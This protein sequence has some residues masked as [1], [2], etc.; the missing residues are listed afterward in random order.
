M[1]FQTITICSEGSLTALV[2]HN[3]IMR[4]ASGPRDLSDMREFPG[5][6]RDGAQE[7]GDN[8]YQRDQSP[9]GDVGRTVR[10]QRYPTYSASA[11]DDGPDQ[12]R[13]KHATDNF[14]NR[15]KDVTHVTMI[16]SFH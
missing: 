10:L 1:P 14:T 7:A 3:A 8:G 16:L 15:A 11:G 6:R 9:F 5:Q 12:E 2:L 4:S 13:A